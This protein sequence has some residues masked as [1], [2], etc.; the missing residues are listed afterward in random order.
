MEASKALSAGQ[1]DQRADRL[2]YF[3]ADLPY[4]GIEYNNAFYQESRP[5]LIEVIK[6]QPPADLQ[7]DQPP[8]QS[9]QAADDSSPENQLSALSKA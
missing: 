7:D 9:T 2:Q 5:S 4:K 1:N 6:Y 3:M 8:A